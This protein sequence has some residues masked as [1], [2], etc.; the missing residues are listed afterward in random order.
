MSDSDTN[1]PTNS[2]GDVSNYGS[3]VRGAHCAASWVRFLLPTSMGIMHFR[4]CETR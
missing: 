1:Y 4:T 2:G 3:P